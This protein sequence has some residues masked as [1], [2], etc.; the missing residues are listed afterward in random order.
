MRPRPF[1]KR[2]PP[3]TA[4]NDY[5]QIFPNSAFRKRASQLQNHMQQRP[6]SRKCPL[7]KRESGDQTNPHRMRRKF[8]RSFHRSFQISARLS[9]ATK[10]D[11]ADKARE[12]RR[13][14][15]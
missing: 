10:K 11:L 15:L 8:T 3:S 13:G 14:W 1:N 2:T 12:K 5:H 9:P 7:D 4:K 6:H